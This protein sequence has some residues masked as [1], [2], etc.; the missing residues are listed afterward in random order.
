MLLSRILLCIRPQSALSE[1]HKNQIKPPHC[2]QGGDSLLQPGCYAE[3]GCISPMPPAPTAE[4]WFCLWLLPR[5][6]RLSFLFPPFL[7]TVAIFNS[8]IAF[9]SALQEPLPTSP[10]CLSPA[11][12]RGSHLTFVFKEPCCLSDCP[13]SL[14]SQDQEAN[15]VPRS[16]ESFLSNFSD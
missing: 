2:S 15:L 7:L 6:P 14:I 10:P 1:V 12:Q 9:S 8:R 16:V 4:K 13:M 5:L 3:L 11:S